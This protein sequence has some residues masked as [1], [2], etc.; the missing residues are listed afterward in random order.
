MVRFT[1]PRGEPGIPGK[2]GTN[3]EEGARG[4]Q[5]PP[6]QFI[7]SRKLSDDPYGSSNNSLFVLIL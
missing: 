3:G 6:G 4:M 2:N 7:I 1:G 5:G